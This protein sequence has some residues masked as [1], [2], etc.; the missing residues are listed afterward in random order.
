MSSAFIGA[1]V[2]VG[3]AIATGG[4]SMVVYAGMA[5]SVVGAITHDKTLS[6]FGAGMSI[7][8]GGWNAFVEQP[9]LAATNAASDAAMTDLANSGSVNGV[10]GASTVADTGL[11]LP[12]GA[13]SEAGMSVAS[14][15]PIDPG[16]AAEVANNAVATAAASNGPS[17]A[18]QIA[19]PSAVQAQVA[20]PAPTALDGSPDFMGPGGKLAGTG[21]G[22]DF[23]G[24]LSSFGDYVGKNQ[25]LFGMLGMG[26]MQG[27]A[28]QNETD[29]NYEINKDLLNMK[30]QQQAWGNTGATYNHNTLASG[31]PIGIVGGAMYTQPR[32]A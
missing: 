23:M 24:K 18:T 29:R 17:T 10:G 4:A 16:A 6:E 32:T 14:A 9:A 13:A 3:L 20:Q 31:K 28:K 15:P 27:I 1:A 11:Q 12:P 2:G 21:G 7:A 30:Q 19:D 5:A 26:A 8:A 22:P 25:N